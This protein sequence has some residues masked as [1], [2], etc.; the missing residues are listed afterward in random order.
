MDFAFF[1]QKC[2]HSAPVCRLGLSDKELLGMQ[3]LCSTGIFCKC[4]L[5]LIPEKSRERLSQIS[6]Q[7]APLNKLN[8]YLAKIFYSGAV[9]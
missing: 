9:H 3:T 8:A 6:E 2:S 5:N 1:I 7:G 4:V